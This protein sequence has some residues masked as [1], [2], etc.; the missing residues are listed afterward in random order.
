MRIAARM[1]GRERR[2]KMRILD[3]SIGRAVVRDSASRAS[4]V[5]RDTQL[6]IYHL[7]VEDAAGGTTLYIRENPRK[8]LVLILPVEFHCCYVVRICPF[9]CCWLF[10]KQLTQKKEKTRHARVSRDSIKGRELDSPHA[11]GPGT[12]FAPPVY[13]R[14]ALGGCVLEYF[15]RTSHPARPSPLTGVE[16][17]VTVSPE[18]S[19]S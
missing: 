12:G 4:R 19:G 6:S 7:S 5:A 15:I 18:S 11:P 10:N 1:S 16:C 8:P 14:L 13:I 9:R 17:H 2:W 3:R